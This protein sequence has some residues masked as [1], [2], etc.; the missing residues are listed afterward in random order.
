MVLQ[1]RSD[2]LLAVVEIFR[3]DETNDRV[4]EQ[5]LEL[6]RHGVR[7]GFERLL[8]DTMM[9]VSGE[10]GTLSRL[11]VHDV[12]S[13]SSTL[14]RTSCVESLAKQL[15]VDAETRIRRLSPCDGLEDQI[16]RHTALDGFELC[17]DVTEHAGL[18]GNLIAFDQLARHLEQRLD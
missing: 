6:A 7:T 15:Q 9:S 3:A 11:E 18:S 17:R 5:W 1:S 13:H 16:H 14:Q 12:V 8:I 10:R 4:H 2:D